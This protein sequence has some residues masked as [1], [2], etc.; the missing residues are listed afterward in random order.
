[1]TNLPRLTRRRLL[2]LS[3]AAA[4]AA[5]PIGGAVFS[6]RRARQTADLLARIEASGGRVHWSNRI[7]R[8]LPV[9]LRGALGE[10]FSREVIV[11]ID[12][13]E[14]DPQ[15]TP[16]HE[17]LA[18]IGH[19][20]SSTGILYLD[21]M[22]VTDGDLR[23]LPGAWQLFSLSL[24]GTPVTDAG[25]EHL[26]EMKKL[27]FL[28][29]DQTRITDAG[30]TRISSLP[31]LQLLE[32]N[33]TKVGDGNIECLAQFPRLVSLSIANTRVTD[34]GLEKIASKLRL[35]HLT[36]GSQAISPAGI[37]RLA[38]SSTLEHIGL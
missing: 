19:Q 26:S 5:L 34:L 35:E 30:L 16:V 22:P 23:Y 31:D 6:W 29:L 15:T 10:F 14:A 4:L 3:A 28:T 25:L 9:W 11:Q 1:M 2:G 37:E 13:T 18:A 33:D 20:F 17:A 38:Q 21:G 32:L 7:P 27:M 8:W 24:T 36:L 12:F